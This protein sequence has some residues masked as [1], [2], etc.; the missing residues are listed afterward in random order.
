MLIRDKLTSF[1]TDLFISRSALRM[2]Q[3]LRAVY[4]AASC[5]KGLRHSLAGDWVGY[6]IFLDFDVVLGRTAH[7][8]N[9]VESVKTR[10]GDIVDYCGI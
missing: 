2:S 9:G 3:I 6:F 10:A 4:Y 1:L 5:V 8:V 7:S